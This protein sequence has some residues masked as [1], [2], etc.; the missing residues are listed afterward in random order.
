MPNKTCGKIFIQY[1]VY[2]FLRQDL[3]SVGVGDNRL[4]CRGN[5]KS[6]RHDRTRSEVGFAGGKHVGVVEEGVG[7]SVNRVRGPPGVM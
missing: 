5:V 2:L 4:G 6:E 1:S 3:D 7:E